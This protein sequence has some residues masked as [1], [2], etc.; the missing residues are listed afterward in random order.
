MITNLHP[1]LAAFPLALLVVVG[2][3]E[4]VQLIRPRINF[5]LVIRVN[6]I[7]AVVGTVA[8]FFSGYQASDLANQ[9]FQVADDVIAEHHLWGRLL[10]F[11]IV[12]CATLQI[13]A[14]VAQH[15]RNWFRC[16]YYIS[17]IAAIALVLR[18]GW[19]GG[20]LVFQHGAGVRAVLTSKV[21]K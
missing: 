16:A 2:L 5:G 21:Q 8:A 3:L 13:L 9:T 20:D 14:T 11:V 18:T 1:P 7:L 10:L 19:L 12:P 17:L 15:G 6:L 4:I